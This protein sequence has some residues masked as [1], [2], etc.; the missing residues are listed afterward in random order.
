MMMNGVEVS[1]VCPAYNEED[2]IEDTVRAV[3]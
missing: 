1:V 2:T 3:I